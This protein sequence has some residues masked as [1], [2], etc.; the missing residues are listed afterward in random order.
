[1]PAQEKP[2]PVVLRH[3]CDAENPELLAAD[4]SPAT[5]AR[6]AQTTSAA[7]TALAKVGLTFVRS[8]CSVP[9]QQLRD[10][11]PPHVPPS[12]LQPVVG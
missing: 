5:P 11:Q 1:L 9:L 4:T 7:L 12:G 3:Q 8:L 6:A 10:E 2:A